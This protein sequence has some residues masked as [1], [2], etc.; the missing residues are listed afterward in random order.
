LVF[1]TAEVFM[2]FICGK[3][4]AEIKVNFLSSGETAKCK[5]CGAENKVPENAGQKGVIM[6]TS[7]E[8]VNQTPSEQEKEAIRA[9]W[10]PRA[11]W[12]LAAAFFFM[13]LGTRRDLSSSPN[14]IVNISKD[15]PVIEVLWGI[16]LFLSIIC[17]LII[18][19]YVGKKTTGAMFSSP[20]LSDLYSYLKHQWPVL[21]SFALMLFCELL[22]YIFN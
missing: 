5:C 3:C 20:P 12:F 22:I 17:Y 8:K 19:W 9:K 6:E 18:F 7:E 4:D 15:S 11:Y 1:A 16:V 21:I 10:L 13:Y 2:N 14:F